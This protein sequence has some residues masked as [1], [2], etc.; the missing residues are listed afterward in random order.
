MWIKQEPNTLDLWN[1]LHF[2]EEKNG[3]FISCLKYSVPL[4]VE[5]IYKM[6]RLEVSGAVR[7]LQWSLG[8]KRLKKPDIFDSFSKNH[9]ILNFIQS[10]QWAPSCFMRRYGRTDGQTDMTKLTVAFRNYVDAP[11]NWGEMMN[12]TPW[13]NRY[14]IINRNSED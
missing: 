6:Q 4:F 2:E 3:E 1:K 7:P 12:F 9:E 11:K 5:Y 8:V 14:I 10:V 13:T